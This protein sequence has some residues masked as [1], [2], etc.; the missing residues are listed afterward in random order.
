MLIELEKVDILFKAACIQAQKIYE[1]TGKKE[2]EAGRVEG[3]S[4]AFGLLNAFVEDLRPEPIVPH[5]P[6]PEPLPLR[7]ANL[8]NALREASQYPD[9][10]DKV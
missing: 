8:L 9:N 3:L 6:E 1:A 10:M 5:S 4:N 7:I 2:F